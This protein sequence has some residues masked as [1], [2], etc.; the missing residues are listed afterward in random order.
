MELL[1]KKNPFAKYIMVTLGTVLMA[2]AINGI[3][4]PLG[5]VTG[6]VSGLA[7]IVKYFTGFVVKGGIPLWVTNTLVN[8]PLVIGAWIVLGRRYVMNTMYATVTFTVALSIVPS[9][10]MP[11]DDIMLMSIFG[12]VLMGVGLGLV[13]AYGCSTGGTD[14]FGAIIQKKFPHYS[15]AQ[16]L[17][18]IDGTIVIVGAAV[19]GLSKALYAIIIVYVTTK[20]MDNILE[21]TDFAKLV[22]VISDEHINIANEILHNIDRGVTSIPVQGMYSNTSRNMLLC[23]VK[24]KEIVALVDL[25]AQI[26]PS[27]FVIVSD[28]REVRGEG[29]IEIKQ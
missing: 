28:A 24:N 27:A 1:N 2:V 19:F 3:F 17:R 16:L 8:I 11:L 7:I 13:F 29:F 4:E 21:G 10:H 6:G 18:Y 9:M 20:V 23:V 26:D 25:V 5:L 12:A 14:L 22:Y 15:V